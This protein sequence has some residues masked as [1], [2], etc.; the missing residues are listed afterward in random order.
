MTL[1]QIL[2]DLRNKIYKPVYLLMGE[3]AYY[4]D[5][6]SDFIKDN[7]LS[8]S[9][10]AFN[11][12]IYYGKDISVLGIDNLVRRFPMMSNH[13]VVIIKEAQ[14]LKKIEDLI[15][16][17]SAPLKSTILVLNY[18]YKNLPKN[19][20]LYKAINK[21]GVVLESKKLYDNQV[22]SWISGYLSKKGCKIDPKYS[23]L[24]T[25]SLGNDLS[26]ISNELDKLVLSLSENETVITPELIERNI[27]ISK[28]FN[29]FELQKALAQRNILKAN[30][31][32]N[33]FGNN[34][35]ENPIFLTIIS[36]YSYYTKILMY[37]FIKD[38]SDRNVASILR[39]NPF[40]V[41]D[42]QLAARNYKS[43]KVVEII[44]IL[45]EYDLKAKGVNAVSIPPIELL[46][47]MI[48]KILH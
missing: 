35:K 31:I 43:R 22:P 18:K 39:I 44:S 9:E 6:L 23:L 32:I 34:Q 8:E 24:I 17:V 29:N 20:K 12:H 3:E 14:D 15:Y 41:R 4:I 2:T 16:Y 25:E 40:F 37:Y 46:K 36:L 28:D 45:R 1:E 48:Y 33:Y 7:I 30:Q 27:G 5:K 13:Q 19:R 26:K 11:Q 10:K 21:V 42:Y 47:E 38:K